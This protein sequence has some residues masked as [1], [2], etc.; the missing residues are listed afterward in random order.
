[1]TPCKFFSQGRCTFGTNCKN[2]HEATALQSLS[3][4]T[5]SPRTERNLKYPVETPICHFF[6]NGVCKYGMACSFRH[7]TLPSQIAATGEPRGVNPTEL[8]NQIAELPVSSLITQDL[9]GARVTFREGAEITSIKLASDFSAIQILGLSP[10]ATPGF[11]EH[12]LS[13]LGFQVP[14]GSIYLKALGVD[15]ATA[16]VQVEDPNFAKRV[17]DNFTLP[18]GTKDN[19]ISIKPMNRRGA[20]GAF[21]NR[22]QLCTVT[23]YW[24]KPSRQAWL[25]YKSRQRAMDAKRILERQRL[26]ERSLTCSIQT[27]SHGMTTTVMIENLDAQTKKQDIYSKLNQPQRPTRITMGDASYSLSD[28]EAASK[29]ERILGKEGKLESFEWQVISGNSKIKATATYTERESA[30]K[31]SLSLNGISL[32]ILANT[33][34]FVAPL[35]SVKYNISS[36]IMLAIMPDIDQLRENIWQS[37]HVSLKLYPQTDPTK[38]FTTLRISGES[39]KHVAEAK[40]AMEELLKGAVLTDGNEALWDSWFLDSKSLAFLNELS[41]AHKLYIHRDARKCHLLLYGGDPESRKK[42]EQLLVEKV[43]TFQSLTHTI[44]LTPEMLKAA[45]QGGMRRIKETFG[46]LATL[47]V[48]RNPKTITILGSLADLRQATTLLWEPSSSDIG[49]DGTEG[50]DCVVC[51]TEATEPMSASCGHVYCKECIAN[52]ASSASESDLPLKCYGQA[53]SCLRKFDLNELKRMLNFSDFENLLQAS[54]DIYIRTHPKE[55]QHCPMPDCL[56]VYR[57]TADNST[58]LCPTCLT[59]ICTTCK[60]PF[61]DGMTCK[62]Y[63]DLSSGGT[64]AFLKYKEENQVKDC[65]QCKVAIQKSHGCNHMQCTQCS[66][67][68]CWFCMA[69]FGTSGE[70]YS[71]MKKLHS[72]IYAD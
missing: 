30:Y 25:V 55:F 5:A 19:K 20:I 17:I 22:L 28:P 41:R 27:T 72:N 26:W 45:M 58:F 56:Q 24:Y 7:G 8:S 14:E 11:V 48:L 16:T 57:T 23:C 9:G 42:V 35:I 54:F 33:K 60:V 47:S 68:I 69:S 61:H 3:S 37:G 13:G 36:A 44:S 12:L 52:Q 62:G 49:T 67:H 50:N 34:M 59:S 38:P 15:G 2:S 1:M 21:A 29:I 64:E 46:T 70:C 53:G 6:L 65:P 32:P 51:W 39:I 4:S 31:A 40:A 66:T 18:Q 10:N 71:H 43:R 63:E